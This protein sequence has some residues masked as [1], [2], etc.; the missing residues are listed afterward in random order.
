MQSDN[1]SM[2]FCFENQDAFIFCWGNCGDDDNETRQ[3]NPRR[4]ADKLYVKRYL[5]VQSEVNYILLNEIF[6]FYIT[7]YPNI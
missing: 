4:F 7:F 6:L 5:Q 3:G 1:K 2:N